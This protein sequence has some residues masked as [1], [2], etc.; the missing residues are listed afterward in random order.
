MVECASDHYIPSLNH[1]GG[2]VAINRGQMYYYL[3]PQMVNKTILWTNGG[4]GC[5]ALEGMLIENGPYIVDEVNGQLNANPYSWHNYANMLYV[6]QPMNTGFSVGNF[7]KNESEIA[8]DMVEFIVN[9]YKIHP[10]IKFNDLYLAGE[11][12]AGQYIPYI[13]KACLEHNIPIKGMIIG[14]A[15][16]DPLTQYPSYIEYAV[17]HDLVDEDYKHKMEQQLVEC[18]KAL[19]SAERINVKECEAMAEFVF[20]YSK[21]THNNKC[22]NMYNINLYEDKGCGTEWPYNLPKLYNYLRNTTTID[23]IHASKSKEWTECQ[24]QSVGSHLNGDVSKPSFYLLPDLLNSIEL[25]LYSGD[26]DFICNHLGTEALLKRLNWKDHQGFKEGPKPLYLNENLIGIV[27]SERNLIY[28]KIKNGSHMLPVD[29]PHI[30]MHMIKNILD[31]SFLHGSSY[32]TKNNKMSDHVHLHDHTK[33]SISG[34]V[35]LIIVSIGLLLF[36]LYKLK[37]K[38]QQHYDLQKNEMGI[39]LERRVL[40]EAEEDE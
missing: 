35:A 12:F 4:P 26:A 3:V 31:G 24:A 17:H 30:S 15:W 19:K 39:E 2:Y 40:Y 20:K 9:L 36:L 14:N 33:P 8:S 13:A 29:Q 11:S 18:N 7:T 32:L 34:V 23:L 1:F 37:R 16:I 27:Q 22:I 5:S 25:Y 28:L 21:K 10:M 6:D 38:Q